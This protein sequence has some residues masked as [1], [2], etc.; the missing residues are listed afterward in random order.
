MTHLSDTGNDKEVDEAAPP[1]RQRCPRCFCPDLRIYRTQP[2]VNGL[3]RRYR[4]C[5][6]CGYNMPP[7][8]KPAADRG[9][10]A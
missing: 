4:K 3:V 8:L 7:D 9:E 2:L 6:L 1:E 10:I 5:R